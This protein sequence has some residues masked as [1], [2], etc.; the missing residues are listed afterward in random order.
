MPGESKARFDKQGVTQKGKGVAD[1]Q[2]GT[3]VY[4]SIMQDRASEI[5]IHL[6]IVVRASDET[7]LQSGLVHAM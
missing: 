1:A 2:L 4:Q 5:M 6:V 3:S 7:A